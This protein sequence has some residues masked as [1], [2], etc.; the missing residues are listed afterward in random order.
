MLVACLTHANQ[1]GNGVSIPVGDG[2]RGKN[3]LLGGEQQQ[4]ETVAN[5]NKS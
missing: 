1:T 5:N 4:L 3:L 2:G